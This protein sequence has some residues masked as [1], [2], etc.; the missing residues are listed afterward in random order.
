[1]N[2]LAFD[3]CF[4][5]CSVAV[6]VERGNMP[7]AIYGEHAVM[8]TGHAEALIPMIERVMSAS[9][10]GFGDLDRIVVTHGPGTFT[11]VRTGVAAARALALAT[12]A[13]LVGVSSLWA[14]AAGAIA[15][16]GPED[17]DAVLV[18]MD[19][20]KGQLYAQVAG[21]DGGALCEP[22]IVSPSEAAS[23]VRGRQVIVCG[24]AAGLVEAAMPSE[25][26]A[27]GPLA[28]AV[29]TGPTFPD[30]KHLIAVADRGSITGSLQPLYLRPP[31]AKPQAGKSLPWSSS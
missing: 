14:I 19:A 13:K 25:G 9:G 10:I 16:A 15:A 11:G 23:L 7:R 17:F 12:P 30:A 6:G 1:M 22:A 5:A 26:G 31:D 18:A 2:V 3:T 20:R 28:G 4:S 21:R 8:E 24:N 27:A 29:V